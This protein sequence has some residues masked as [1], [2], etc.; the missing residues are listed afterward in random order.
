VLV[1]CLVHERGALVTGFLLDTGH[2]KRSSKRTVNATTDG[3]D[4]RSQRFTYDTPLLSAQSI[5]LHGHL[6]DRANRVEGAEVAGAKRG[7]TTVPSELRLRIGGDASIRLNKRPRS[8]SVH[9]VCTAIEEFLVAPEARAAP[10]GCMET[11]RT[12]PERARLT[13]TIDE[14]AA[15]LGISRSS[16]YECAKRGEIP[17]VRFGR[18]IVVP[19]RA[20]LELLGENDLE[21]S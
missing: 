18:R 10:F 14:V 5:D 1:A 19:R 16:A 15:T 21:A 12:E 17:T 11:H 2:Q 4:Q 3:R 7:A 20:V 13:L 8:T 6:L 9:N